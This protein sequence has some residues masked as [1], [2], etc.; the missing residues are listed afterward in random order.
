MAVYFMCR[1][2]LDLGGQIGDRTQSDVSAI[3]IASLYQLVPGAIVS[4]ICLAIDPYVMGRNLR[5]WLLLQGIRLDTT[6]RTWNGLVALPEVARPGFEPGTLGYE[7][8][9]ITRFSTALW[10]TAGYR[11]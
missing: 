9:E 10:S 2:L 1:Q 6:S 11:R 3:H 7:P 8:S 5:A 4:P